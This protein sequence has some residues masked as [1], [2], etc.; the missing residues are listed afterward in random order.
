MAMAITGVILFVALILLNRNA[1]GYPSF[2]PD[3]VEYGGF[4]PK[5]IMGLHEKVQNVEISCTV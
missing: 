2:I 3:N 5:Y 1:L 4:R